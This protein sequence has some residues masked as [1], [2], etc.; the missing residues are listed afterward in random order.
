MLCAMPMPMDWDFSA[1]FRPTPGRSMAMRAGLSMVKLTG[2]SANG[3][4]KSSF[5]CTRSPGIAE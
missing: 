4:E 2:S 3:S 1:R 5:N